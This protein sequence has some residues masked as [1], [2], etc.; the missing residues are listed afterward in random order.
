M[1]FA[2]DAKWSDTWSWA[3][4]PLTYSLVSVPGII[5]L[6]PSAG[7]SLGG[8]ITADAG[9]S[10]TADFTS[11]MPNGTVHLDFI[12][13]NESNSYGWTTEKEATYSVKEGGQIT[14]KPFIDFKVEFAC[15]LFD[16]LLDLS[17]GVKAE[18]SFPFITTATATQN[19]NATGALTFPNST[20]ANGLSEEIAF[21]F[22]VTAFATEWVDMTLY[23]YKT[24]IYKGCLDLSG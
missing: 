7:I 17:T 12:N 13:W 3:P 2:I 24:D 8:A 9:G 16:G 15:Q 14:L 21:D 18:P 4:D 23:D 6:G 22:G 20:C 1:T 11:S 5:S 19:L 10:V